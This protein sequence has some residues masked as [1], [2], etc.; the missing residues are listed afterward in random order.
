[1]D[2]NAYARN[3]MRK[4]THDETPFPLTKIEHGYEKDLYKTLQGYKYL[5]EEEAGV[6][7]DRDLINKDTLREVINYL[8][9]L[10]PNIARIQFVR[11]QN[12]C[13]DD[14]VENMEVNVFHY[15]T[16]NNGKVKFYR[17]WDY[18]NSNSLEFED[19]DIWDGT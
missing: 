7:D 14:P 9:N 19:W 18:E 10:Y 13:E 15:N 11:N 17:L 5:T 4:L 3:N 12:S 8:E 16:A 1:M 2:N 6:I